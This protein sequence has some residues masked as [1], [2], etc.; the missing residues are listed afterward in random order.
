[1]SIGKQ[2]DS[3]VCLVPQ[4]GEFS[5]LQDRAERDKY[6]C[7]NVLIKY[8]RALN[9]CKWC[10][11]RCYK[12]GVVSWLCWLCGSVVFPII[13][14]R[15]YPPAGDLI[16]AT[17]FGGIHCHWS[18]KRNARK[19]P[20]WLLKTSKLVEMLCQYFMGGGSCS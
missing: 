18:M 1:M 7:N 11:Q 12:L 6:I 9:S 8:C 10:Y 13:L 5:T 3:V 16:I 17:V 14:W 19:A 2:P 20:G 4:G 15:K